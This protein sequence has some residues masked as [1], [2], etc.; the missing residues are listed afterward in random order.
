MQHYSILYILSWWMAIYWWTM[1]LKKYQNLSWVY[2]LIYTALMSVWFIFYYLF[3]SS[4]NFS[5]EEKL[6]LS[7]VNFWISPVILISFLLFI[8]NF[9]KTT[10]SRSTYINIKNNYIQFLIFS[11]YSIGI[12][13][14]SVFTD[15]IINSIIIDSS[16]IYRESFG[17]LSF[18]NTLVYI[19]FIPLSVF[20]YFRKKR[21]LWYIDRARI[22][23]VARIKLSF[24]ILLI[25]V[26]VILPIW[27]IWILENQIILF[28]AISV[29]MVTEVVSK[30]HFLPARYNLWKIFAILFSGIIWI[31]VMVFVVNPND[32]W[33][34]FDR[35][36]IDREI[37]VG[38]I[39][40][41]YAITIIVFLWIYKIL[42]EKLF[43][44]INTNSLASKYQRIEKIIGEPT[45]VDELDKL[46]RES[47]INILDITFSKIIPISQ[48]ERKD[49]FYIHYFYSKESKGFYV[50][51]PVFISEIQ[52]E[53]VSKDFNT[54]PEWTVLILPLYWWKNKIIWLF[55][56]WNKKT[57][58]NFDS[59]EIEEIQAFTKSISKNI[60]YIETYT[61]LEDISRNLDRKIDEKTIEYNALISRQ[62]EFIATLSHEIKAPITSTLLQLDNLAVDI[63]S[64]WLTQS[65]IQEEL[66]S[67]WESLD[68]AKTLLAQIFST[69][70]LEK[71]QAILYPEKVD[72]V[73]VVL[74]QYHIQ[75]RV[76]HQ[77]IYT[78]SV[79]KQKIFINLDK[80]QFIQVL[81]NLF[82]NAIK[83]AHPKNPEIH[84][85]IETD[86]TNIIIGIE[87]NGS[88]LYGIDLD[89]IFEKYSIWKNSIWLGIWLY[90]CK[91]IVE[92]HGWVI[93][94]KRGKILWGIRM[95]IL[96]PKG[97][98]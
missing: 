56:V 14:L 79:P 93:R 57:K 9:W 63:E 60:K 83:F 42:L 15:K 88:G 10:P 58:E 78:E 24:L 21:L 20:L 17:E 43:I 85:D 47:F 84:L 76:N 39:I 2:F 52:E 86:D 51:D 11:I 92:L 3:F 37:N 30:Y 46:I 40:S 13:S 18:I 59:V 72:I 32:I 12:F 4:Y 26:Q 64:P 81:T 8:F 36:I 29:I 1:F 5:I 54:I 87:D 45:S 71:Q 67:I 53:P 82:G 27:D 70:Y 41:T 31:I 44:G 68:H 25:T 48:L 89:Q 73:D 97:S 74:S 66:V 61:Q 35:D 98:I 65:Q 34:K 28:F 80:T 49:S 96:L 69:E 19:W 62:R 95:E 16:W 91:R 23:K 7:R 33:I 22:S 75:K 94:A 38:Q 6:I 50:N 90:L 55:C 77:Y